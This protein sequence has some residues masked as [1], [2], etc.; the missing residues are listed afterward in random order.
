MRMPVA[1]E[2][3]F[4]AQHVAIVGAADDDR[5]AG[6]DLDQADPAQDQGAHDALAELGLFDHQLAQPARRYDERLDRF[7]GSR[8]DERRAVG[9]L[10]Q[11]AHK[12]ARAVGHDRLGLSVPAALGDFDPAA[13]D[14]KSARRHLAG[15]HHMF[16]RPIGSALAEPRQPLDLRRLQHRKHLPAPGLDQ[17][18]YRLRHR[19]PQQP[20]ATRRPSP[21]N[22][23]HSPSSKHMGAKPR[24][25]NVRMLRCNA[26]TPA[27]PIH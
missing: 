17:R 15:R 27:T 4:E 14:H 23:G 19:F 10:R 25:R 2:E 5:A 7:G 9:E 22:P 1:G 6:A 20:T 8:V 18:V 24:T 16:A 21:P 11:F 3:P 13:Q 26:P 12:R